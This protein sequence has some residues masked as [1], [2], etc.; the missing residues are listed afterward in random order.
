MDLVQRKSVDLQRKLSSIEEEFKTWQK[1]SERGKPFEKHHTQIRR[2]TDLLDSLLAKIRT[3]LKDLQDRPAQVVALARACETNILEL[4]RI[5]EYFRSKL[6]LRRI[7]RFEQYLEAAD[8]FAWAC[9]RP[10]RDRALQAREKGRKGQP[11]SPLFPPDKFKGPPLVFLNSGWS[12]FT[13]PRDFAFQASLTPGGL[14]KAADFA[15]VTQA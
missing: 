2:I 14:L 4:Y 5:W 13:V 8:E 1:L 7:D 10:A 12:P 3:G 15:A 9:Y 6:A 11:A